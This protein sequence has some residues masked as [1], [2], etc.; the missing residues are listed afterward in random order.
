MDQVKESGNPT[1]ESPAEK[2]NTEEEDK[3]NEKNE[4]EVK[5]DG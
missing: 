2:E 5:D 1:A 3:E 4:K